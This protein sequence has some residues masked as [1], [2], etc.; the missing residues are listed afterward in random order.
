MPKSSI[1][2]PLKNLPGLEFL[3]SKYAIWQPWWSGVNIMILMSD[4]FLHFSAENEAFLKKAL[5]VILNQQD[6]T[7]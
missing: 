2:K 6:I 5:H 7:V 4:D 3:V 1:V